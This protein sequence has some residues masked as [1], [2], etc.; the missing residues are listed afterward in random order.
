MIV[1]ER[2]IAVNGFLH[3]RFD[4]NHNK[5]VGKG[6]NGLDIIRPDEWLHRDN[7]GKQTFQENTNYLET[8]PQVC[9]VLASND[10]YPYQVGDKLF[11]HYMAWETAKCGDIVTNEA[12][13]IADYVFFTILEDGS[14]K[15]AD[16]NYLGK[17]IYTDDLITKSGIFLQGGK[18]KALQIKITHIPEKPPKW[19]D[20]FPANIGEIAISCDGYNYEFKY[21]GEKYIRLKNTEIA[22]T[23]FD[24]GINPLS[25]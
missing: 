14:L 10:N 4:P 1:G 3:V 19:H 8:K 25:M 15:M 11:V 23:M 5:V 20:K 7:E 18:P 16:D 17:Q 12:F 24:D 9:T 6:V 2:M 22:G 13:I 21:N